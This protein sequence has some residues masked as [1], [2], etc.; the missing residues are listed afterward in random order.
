[1][2]RVVLLLFVLLLFLLILS[3]FLSFFLSLKAAVGIWAGSLCP[4]HPAHDGS[5][6]GYACMAVWTAAHKKDRHRPG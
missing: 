6:V 4:L 2:L 5:A 1:M 3:A